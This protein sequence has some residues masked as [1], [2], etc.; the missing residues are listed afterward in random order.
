MIVKCRFLFIIWL[1]ILNS[2]SFAEQPLTLQDCLS[3]AR[4]NYPKLIQRKTAIEQSEVGVTAA[5]SSYYPSLN[6]SIPSLNLSSRR[7]EER[8]YSA[9]IGVGYTLY[10]GGSIRAGV[11]AAKARVKMAEENYRSAEDEVILAVKEAFFTILQ[12]QQQIA[13]AEE[14]LKRRKEDL[15]LIKLKYNAGRESSPAVKEAEANLLQ[16][17]Y[18]KKQAEEELTLAQ[19]EL[20]LLLGRPRRSEVS[21]SHQDEDIQFPS[22]DKL[23]EEAKAQRP[24]I[25]SQR[26]NTDVLK[27]QLTQAK[28][29]YFPK[30]SLSSSWGYTWRSDETFLDQQGDWSAAISFSLPTIFDGFSRKAKIKEATL[31]LKEQDV[32]LVELEQQIEEEIEQAY[33]RWELAEKV[34][35]VNDKTLQAAREMYQL[36]KLQYEQGLTSYFFLQQK[37]SDLSRAE[38]SYVGALYNLR[39]Y[40]ARLQKAWGRSG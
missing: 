14:V 25:R 17:E 3:L 33:S 6:L 12:K 24:D 9:S 1:V 4:E 35:E 40:S 21:I 31:S 23:I 11:K 26:I 13:L 15:V 20:N 5:Y 8:S 34:I 7:G 27:A 16:A 32:V 36:T 38:N 10:Q 30:I 39:V 22:L 37:E 29:T 19:I 18:D 2:S 28:S